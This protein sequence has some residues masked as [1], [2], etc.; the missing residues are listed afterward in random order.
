MKREYNAFFDKVTSERSDRQLL[1]GAL[2]EAEKIM[3]KKKINRKALTVPIA[4]ALSL[5]V[6][7]VGVG[8]AFGYEHLTTIFGGNESLLSEIQTNVFEDNDG[9]VSVAIEQLATD[10]RYMHAFVHYTALDEQGQ[11]WLNEKEFIRDI[12]DERGHYHS[13]LINLI[14]TDDELPLGYPSYGSSCFEIEEQR[15]ETDRYFYLYR[16]LGH[17]VEWYNDDFKQYFGYVL[18]DNEI[19]VPQ[20]TGYEVT[21]ST[22]YRIVGDER[23]SK[24]ITPTY[25]ELS[26]FSFVLYAD[27]DYGMITHEDLPSGGYAEYINI[28]DEEYDREVSDLDFY[29]VLTDGTKVELLGTSGGPLYKAE[30]ADGFSDWIIGRGE[31]FDVNGLRYRTQISYSVCIDYNMIAGIEIGGVYYDLIAE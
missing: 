12:V 9:H 7:A 1:E 6:V 22:R 19:R 31:I 11:E 30:W 4:A 23:C 17:P 3:Q 8:A 26:P 18:T 14:Y 13:Y 15:T 20:L 16:S 21:V 2:R 29:I 24:Y 28:S 27:D 25:L 5:V 10:G